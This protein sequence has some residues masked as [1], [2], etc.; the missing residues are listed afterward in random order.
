MPVGLCGELTMIA[1][2]LCVT[3]FRSPSTSI[4]KPRPSCTNGT[5]RRSQPAI[6]MTGE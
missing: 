6:A 4:L 1:L 2:V 5:A 3:A